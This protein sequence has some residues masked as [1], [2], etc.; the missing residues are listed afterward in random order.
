MSIDI[1]R[2][3][4]IVS[5]AIDFEI[6]K[7]SLTSRLERLAWP[8]SRTSIRNRTYREHIKLNIRAKYILFRVVL[9]LF[10]SYLGKTGIGLN[11]W[12]YESTAT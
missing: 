11:D 2:S 9:L 1:Q 8:T 12:N 7:L 4:E 6:R 10:G 5:A 3:K